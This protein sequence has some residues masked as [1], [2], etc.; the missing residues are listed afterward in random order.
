MKLE[1]IP[2]DLHEIKKSKSLK[3]YP[4]QNIIPWFED[5]FKFTLQNYLQA[6]SE[7]HILEKK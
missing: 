5:T 4:S 3:K 7:A 1:L 6:Q 2:H